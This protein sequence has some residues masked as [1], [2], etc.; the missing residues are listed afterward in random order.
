MKQGL[1][2]YELFVAE[3]RQVERFQEICDKH[4]CVQ[5][6]KHILEISKSLTT[7]LPALRA[8]VK[9]WTPEKRDAELKAAADAAAAAE[10]SPA[11]PEE[12]VDVDGLHDASALP[13]S[14]GAASITSTIA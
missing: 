12:A 2:V 9:D 1:E 13:R 5:G 8:H 14:P 10:A 7:L 6:S 3:T 4:D 11:A